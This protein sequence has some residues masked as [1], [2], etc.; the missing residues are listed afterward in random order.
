MASEMLL[1]RHEA[2]TIIGLYAGVLS[3]SWA[4]YLSSVCLDSFLIEPDRIWRSGDNL[5]RTVK[6]RAKCSWRRQVHATARILA[7]T[8]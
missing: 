4:Y 3:V 8:T 1:D 2:E 6:V 5:K 7:Y